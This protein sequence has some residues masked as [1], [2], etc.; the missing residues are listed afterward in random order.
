VGIP[1][2]ER[3]LGSYPHELSGGMRQRVV[4]PMALACSPELILADEPTTALDVTIQAQILSLIKDMQRERQVSTLL[5][6]HDLGVVAQTCQRVMV[7]YAGKMVEHA[8]VRE[9]FKEPLHPYTQG[10][11]ASLPT[12]GRARGG[13]SPIPGT[14][15]GLL[16]PPTGCAFHPRC[17]KAFARCRQEPPP[18]IEIGPDRQV[19][20]WLHA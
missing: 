8:P 3:R 2:P 16:D 1:N 14:V 11:L 7:M 13:L 20:C 18:F 10:L 19:R 5:I 15:P 9:L 17:A 4:V 12:P 6:T